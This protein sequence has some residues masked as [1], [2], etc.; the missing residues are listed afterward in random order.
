M[1]FEGAVVAIRPMSGCPDCPDHNGTF[2]RC[3]SCGN[4]ASQVIK[5]ADGLTGRPFVGFRLYTAN[6]TRDRDKDG[7]ACET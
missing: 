6:H 3:K 1:R 4:S 7:V 2:S 5:R